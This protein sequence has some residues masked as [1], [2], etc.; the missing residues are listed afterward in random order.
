M[1]N[2]GGKN[3]ILGGRKIGRMA[4]GANNGAPAS[5]GIPEEGGVA[6]GS[7]PTTVTSSEDYDDDDVIPM[8]CS[9]LP[10]ANTPSSPQAVDNA[11]STQP[12]TVSLASTEIPAKPV[13]TT[14]VDTE[15]HVIPVSAVS[16]HFLPSSVAEMMMRNSTFTLS[17]SAAITSGPVSTL[18]APSRSLTYPA[19]T[20]TWVQRSGCKGRRLVLLCLNVVSGYQGSYQR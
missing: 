4:M 20:P 14:P 19:L 15:T 16:S 10:L 12:T 11:Q 9:P 18:A 7:G 17:S 6:G 5:S 2:L 13:T 1:E 3:W 8:I